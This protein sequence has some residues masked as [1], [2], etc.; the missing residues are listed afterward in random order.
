MDNRPEE[1]FEIIRKIKGLDLTQ[2]NFDV[3][4]LQKDAEK[5]K[6]IEKFTAEIEKMGHEIYEVVGHQFITS[7]G[8]YFISHKSEIEYG[9]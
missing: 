8:V 4:N 5:E 1:E 6:Y 7:N 2:K 3:S 9:G